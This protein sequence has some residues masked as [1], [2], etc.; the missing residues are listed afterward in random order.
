MVA[1][2]A[3]ITAI[4]LAG[5]DAA[6]RLADGSQVTEVTVGAGNEGAVSVVTL[7]STGE[8]TLAPNATSTVAIIEVEFAKGQSQPT[9]H[10]VEGLRGAARPV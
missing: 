4:T 8:A 3:R 1:E 5:T 2:G 6:S 7:S 9:L 10:F